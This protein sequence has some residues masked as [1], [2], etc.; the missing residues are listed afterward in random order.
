MYTGHAG[1]NT[2]GV[3]PRVNLLEFDGRHSYRRVDSLALFAN[4]WVSRAGS[5]TDGCK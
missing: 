1:F 3:N 2:P 4:T 5:L